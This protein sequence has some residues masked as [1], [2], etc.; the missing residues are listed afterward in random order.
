M[1]YGKQVMFWRRKPKGR[2]VKP[3]GDPIGKQFK[4]YE[5]LSNRVSGDN[6]KTKK[7]YILNLAEEAVIGFEWTCHKCKATN[8]ERDIDPHDMKKG[9]SI[10]CGLCNTPHK[11][12]F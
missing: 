3:T 7:K 11:V 4:K 5:L 6:M 12:M 10:K 1:D 8:N 9:T 2:G